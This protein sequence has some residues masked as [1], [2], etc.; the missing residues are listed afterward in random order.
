[1]Q[2]LLGTV[3]LLISTLLLW[4]GGRGTKLEVSW[5]DL[6]SGCIM[7]KKIKDHIQ[8]GFSKLYSSEMCMAR[9]DSPI[10]NFSCCFLSEEERGWMGRVVDK[11][12]IK[13]DLWA[14]KPFKALGLDGLHVDFFQYFWRDV[15]VSVCHE[16]KKAFS[17]GVVP[18]F[19]NTTL[20]TLIPKCNNPK[21]LANYK[22]I[23]L[24]NSVYKV[25]SKVLVARIRPLLNRL[26][27]P[28][29]TAFVPG[30][31]S[32]DNVL[33]AQELIYTM[34]KMKG[35][36]GYMAVKGDLEKAYDRLEWSYINVL[37]AFRFPHNLIKV[38]MSCI[39]T[40]SISV[41]VNG[42]ALDAF[43][44][45]RGRRQGDPLSPYLFILCI[46][47]LGNLI[48]EK[49]SK[50]L[51]CPLKAS[52]GNLKISHLFFSNDLILF[53]KVNDEICDVILE[54]L[55]T[56]CM[57]SGQK[58]SSEKSRIYFSSNVGEE[59]KETVCEKLGM[60]ETNNFGKYLGSPLKH[61]GAP[62]G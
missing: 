7:R 37:L 30:R 27:S 14:L 49:C 40:S 23:S 5:M 50:G 55:R 18:E 35:R 31:R 43:N 41:L 58:I 22:P 19:L 47:Y 17:L 45:S 44:P 11:E 24:C 12:E 1:M 42:N 33:I 28:I 34:D 36:E 32:V 60:F 51:W 10:A 52:R 3:T 20:I 21:S 16:V 2:L 15:Q 57:E 39:S 26:I 8:Q 59:L 9:M 53:G 54:V 48:E 56:F 38:I 6:V 62:R 13:A 29:Q 4:L 46:E 61:K 25:I